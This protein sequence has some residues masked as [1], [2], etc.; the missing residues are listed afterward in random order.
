LAGSSTASTNVVIASS[1]TSLGFSQLV[2]T[3]ASRIALCM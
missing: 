2:K 3:F 1:C